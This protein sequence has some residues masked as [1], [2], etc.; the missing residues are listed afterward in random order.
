[1]KTIRDAILAIVGAAILATCT[2]IILTAD[3]S[4]ILARIYALFAAIA[5]L[6]RIGATG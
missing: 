4:P 3:Y 2:I 1:M 6:L 5:G